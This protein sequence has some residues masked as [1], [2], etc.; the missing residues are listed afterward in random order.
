MGGI[1]S[2]IFFVVL[3]TLFVEV[4]KISMRMG[5]NALNKYEK[6]YISTNFPLLLH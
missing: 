5:S 6:Y 2:A 1:S 4:I 3:L